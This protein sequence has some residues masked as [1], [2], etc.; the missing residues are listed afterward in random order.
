MWAPTLWG[1]EVHC[2]SGKTTEQDC[3]KICSKESSLTK[4]VIINSFFPI[5]EKSELLLLLCK[6]LVCIPVAVD[7]FWEE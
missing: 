6:S 2:E 4:M 1:Y 5:K 7:I 3:S